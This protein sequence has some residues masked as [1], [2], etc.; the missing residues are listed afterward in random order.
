MD[1]IKAIAAQVGVPEATAA[2][3]AGGVLGMVRDSMAADDGEDAAS[4][5][6]AAI[7]ELGGWREAAA[8]LMSDAAG[9]ASPAASAGGG[10][11]GGLMK[12]AGGGGLLGDLTEE[13]LGK[14]A[15]QTAALASV[16]SGLGLDASK[17]AAA[18]PV[19][20]NFLE[21][22]LSGDLL[23]KAM[24]AAPFLASI[25]GDRGDEAGGG[26]ATVS[27]LLGSLFGG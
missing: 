3:L 23:S 27:G 14:D 22:R 16:F 20:L 5:V 10:V 6:D 12:A 26:G 4:A 25:I 2:G 19:V 13:V 7:P 17:A 8:G 18:A 21:E 1:F 11:L 24:A 9:A 15:R